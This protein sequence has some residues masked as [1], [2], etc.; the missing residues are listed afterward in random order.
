M[1]PA[2]LLQ[3]ILPIL[4]KNFIENQSSLKK[5]KLASETPDL[6]FFPRKF[7]T[8]S[9]FLSRLWMDFLKKTRQEFLLVGSQ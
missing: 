1:R 5:V 8:I 6:P 9:S 7:S 2:T 4:A 3:W